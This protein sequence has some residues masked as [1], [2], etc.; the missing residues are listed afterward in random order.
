MQNS[1]RN[2]FGILASISLLYFAV[3]S[4]ISLWKF[5]GFGS[6]MVD[7]GH[8]TQMLWSFDKFGLPLT[9]LG[10]P[11]E[12]QHRFGFHFSPILLLLAP[13]YVIFGK[14]S[15]F[16]IHC[17]LIS[18]TSLIIFRIAQQLKFSDK[19]SFIFALVY[20]FNPVTL[21]SLMW[22]FMEVSIAAVLISTAYLMLLKHRFF[23]FTMAL[24]LLL[25]TKEQFG[26]A[27]F[28]FGLLWAWHRR[29][30]G[31]AD[32][33][34]GGAIALLGLV[35]FYLIVFEAM[36]YLLGAE[37][38]VMLDPD[39]TR[40]IDRFAWIHKPPLEMIGYLFKILTEVFSLFYLAILFGTFFFMP[41]L[42]PVFIFPAAGDLF[43]NLFSSVGLMRNVYSYH[44]LPIII[45]FVVATLYGLSKIEPKTQKRFRNYI[46]MLTCIFS[47]MFIPVPLPGNFYLWKLHS[48]VNFEDPHIAEI[49][50][51]IGDEPIAAQVNVGGFF[52]ER[53]E[54]YPYPDSLDKSHYIIM[55]KEIPS[56]NDT[57]VR[58]V[59]RVNPHQA[60]EKLLQDEDFELV[61]Q[62][63]KWF[64]F[65]RKDL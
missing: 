11:Y 42:A 38:H 3:F 58:D 36:P 37:K 61:Y 4:T 9:T 25:F 59:I 49:K 23:P 28:G 7:I 20:L 21:N 62:R 14:L 6:S 57:F 40:G 19:N 47:Y 32:F 13:F 24:I 65:K 39:S 48:F 50:A 26:A 52:T 46:I 53:L 63:E 18:V 8:F 51:I 15:L 34:K 27:V 55:H 16:Y 60:I 2:Y 56:A 1:N 5:W 41:A 64:V 54:A 30:G 45:C 17:F 43:I 31:K 10:Y 33:I 12:L 22:D 29:S 35:S 44:S